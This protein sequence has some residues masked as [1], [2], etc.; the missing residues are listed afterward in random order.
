MSISHEDF[1]TQ[2]NVGILTNTST[3]CWPKWKDVHDMKQRQ[4]EYRD[5]EWST[6]AS[7]YTESRNAR[8][9]QL[10]HQEG[11]NIQAFDFISS[12]W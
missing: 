4:E 5:N 10:P 11:K 1:T 8:L 2:T 6:E 12:R 7:H 3:I 9:Y